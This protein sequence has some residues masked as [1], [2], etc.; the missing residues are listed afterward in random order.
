METKHRIVRLQKVYS[1]LYPNC[2]DKK[3][4]R[5]TYNIFGW[6]RSRKYLFVMLKKPEYDRKFVLNKLEGKLSFCF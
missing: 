1:H 6:F 4:C 2:P 3:T 5:H